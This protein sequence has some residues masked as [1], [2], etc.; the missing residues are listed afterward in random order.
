MFL[1]FVGFDKNSPNFFT[2]GNLFE[3]LTP[4]AGKF[5]FKIPLLLGYMCRYFYNK[6]VSIEQ[7]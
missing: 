1:I 4:K 6:I 2:L 3:C 7:R 5:I